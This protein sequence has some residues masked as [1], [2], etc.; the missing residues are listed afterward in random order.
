[1]FNNL[2]GR[3]FK[4][5]GILLFLFLES[6]C[7]YLVIRFNEKQNGIYIASVNKLSAFFDQAYDRWTNLLQLP[8]LL[9]SLAG[10]NA[11]IRE[12]L[13]NEAVQK[14]VKID[15]VFNKKTS[16]RYQ[17]I[18]AKVINNS[19]NKQR[20]YIVLDRG[21]RQGIQP[22]SAVIN[23]DGVVGIVRSV[24]DSY[25]VVMSLLHR[26]TRIS[27]SIR[28]KGYFGSLLWD[29]VDVRRF[30]LEDIPRHAAVMVGDSVQTS[31]YSA[32]FPEGIP[33]GTV[34]KVSHEP[35]S[36][37]HSIKVLLNYDL[38]NL[39]Y[40]YV[41]IN[42]DKEEQKKLEREVQDE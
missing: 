37:S 22:H 25:A 40:V 7:F 29:G 15:S 5:G 33:I 32:I 35:G 23:K 11:K 4:Y 12:S 42:M 27:A 19:I 39:N 31:G 8:E 20:N 36:N 17:F 30:D 28:N 38:S 16:D 3:F 21:R 6:I 2:F 24:S 41:I 14:R 34:E 13:A 18:E 1:M 10:E 26:Q 9:D